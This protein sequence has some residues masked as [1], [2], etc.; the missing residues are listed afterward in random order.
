MRW[1]SLRR[2]KNQI[3]AAE[4]PHR[5]EKRRVNQEITEL[6][7]SRVEMKQEILEIEVKYDRI[8][9]MMD[10]LVDMYP[11]LHDHGPA[12]RVPPGIGKDLTQS[13]GRAEP[14]V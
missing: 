6:R 12:V 10:R 2:K 11:Q 4:A 13:E 9:D 3:E 1:N 14:D 7:A 8:V 5:I